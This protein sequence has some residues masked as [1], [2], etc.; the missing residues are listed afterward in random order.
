MPILKPKVLMN[1]H[2]P[3]L[4]GDTE[5]MFSSV[6]CCYRV[7]AIASAMLLLG[8]FIASAQIV[9]QYDT[10]GPGNTAQLAIPDGNPAGV[11]DTRTI[12]APGQTQIQSVSVTLGLSSQFNGDLYAYLVHGEQICILLNRPGRTASDSFGY[13]DQGLNITL[14]DGA[15]NDIHTYQL[16]S[17]PLAGN[18]LA[19]SWQPD[20]RAV[21][22]D[23]VTTSDNRTALLT[24]FYNTDPNGT[25]T[26]YVADMHGGGTSS[27]ESW[28]ME[29]TAVPEPYESACAVGALLGAFACWRTY[30][31]RLRP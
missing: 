3:K 19:G 8:N 14:A 22:P 7:M 25:W 13:A 12:S 21:D 18:S 23:H 31:R 4:H 26:L 29:I 17:T 2:S 24:D 10:F 27:L 15:A 9:G 30:R 11:S 6:H 1:I 16:V 28:G 20:G 5:P